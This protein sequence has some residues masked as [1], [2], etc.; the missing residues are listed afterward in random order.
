MPLLK[1]LEKTPKDALIYGHIS[2]AQGQG[3][4]GDFTV[5]E[6]NSIVADMSDISYLELSANK[7][8]AGHLEI[9]LGH[10]RNRSEHLDMLDVSS[11]HSAPAPCKVTFRKSTKKLTVERLSLANLAVDTLPELM[12]SLSSV[13]LLFITNIANLD[14]S[15]YNKNL[16]EAEIIG[17]AVQSLP[18]GISQSTKLEKLILTYTACENLPE[19]ISELRELRWVYCPANKLK[20]CPDL[21]AARRV[22]LHSNR[23]REMPDWV[24]DRIELELGKQ[25]RVVVFLGDNPMTRGDQTLNAAHRVRTTET[26]E[27][28]GIHEE[29]PIPATAL[30]RRTAGF[31]IDLSANLIAGLPPWMVKPPAIY[32][33]TNAKTRRGRLLYVMSPKM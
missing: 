6:F 2:D 13:D 4:D 11:G 24:A 7:A 32:E 30:E 28:I 31:S 20:T 8:Q 10:L 5:S 3:R 33:C 16:K 27:R 14:S 17:S 19:D 1:C 29:L 15:I 9:S 18:D 26:R 25:S 21:P 23:I 22:A 12:G